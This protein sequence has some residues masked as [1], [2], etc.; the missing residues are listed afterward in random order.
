MSSES[1]DGRGRLFEPGRYLSLPMTIMERTDLTPAAKLVWMALAGHVGRHGLAAWPSISRLAQRTGLSQPTVKRA[2]ASLADV[3]LVEIERSP[4]ESNHYRIRQPEVPQSPTNQYQNDTGQPA[5]PEMQKPYQNDT[6]IKKT[7]VS[8]CDDTGIKKIPHPDQNDP[9]STLRTTPGSTNTH[10]NQNHG[11]SHACAREAAPPAIT[12]EEKA[13]RWVQLACGGGL[14]SGWRE[15]IVQC[16]RD[17]QAAVIAL[18][19][20][21]A[22]AAA[23]AATPAN[24]Q[25]GF[26]WVMKHLERQQSRQR[27]QDAQRAKQQ[28]ARTSADEVRRRQEEEQQERLRKRREYWDSRSEQLRQIYRQAARSQKFA[29]KGDDARSLERLEGMAIELAWRDRNDVAEEATA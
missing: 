27:Q 12:S 9:R 3:G 21:E 4:G 23:E 11:E 6:G 18:V 16:Y 14:P 26:G 24:R 29:P 1:E 15:K 17:G 2:V 13:V 5:K 28:Q 7:P 25:F 20:A 19:D 22:I 10:T 8:K